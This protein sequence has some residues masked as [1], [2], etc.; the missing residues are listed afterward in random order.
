MISFDKQA[1][2]NLIE[3]VKTHG[4]TIHTLEMNHD[5][6]ES[7]EYVVDADDLTTFLQ[8]L[9]DLAIWRI[10]A[11]SDIFRDII[12]SGKPVL[13]KLKGHIELTGV[14]DAL[15]EK[16]DSFIGTDTVEFLDLESEI[17]FEKLILRQ[18]NV[19]SVVCHPHSMDRYQNLKILKLEEL[20]CY[21]YSGDTDEWDVDRHLLQMIRENK[22][23]RKITFPDAESDINASIVEAICHNCR[24]LQYLTLELS[25]DNATNLLG[26]YQLKALQEIEISFDLNFTRVDLLSELTRIEMQSIKKVYFHS[27]PDEGFDFDSWMILENLGKHWKNIEDFSIHLESKAINSILENLRNLKQLTVSYESWDGSVSIFEYDTSIY[28]SLESLTIFNHDPNAPFDLPIYFLKTLPN[29]NSL[30]VH[31]KC[32]FKG[33]LQIDALT[34]IPKLDDL[35]ITF[36]VKL[37]KL[38]PTVSDVKAIKELCRSVEKFEIN[39]STAINSNFT[40]QLATLLENDDYIKQEHCTKPEEKILKLKNFKY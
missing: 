6:D 28:S 23:L 29:L 1:M 27:L 19:K 33:P 26:I 31:T 2:D 20:E 4:S 36:E 18:R 5:R 17:I 3:V 16:L 22:D 34:Q 8:N 37:S 12:G 11:K 40:H 24:V 10:E 13:F 30:T 38:I 39:F 9:P 35:T 15:I 7:S 21:E 25:D 14:S 32:E